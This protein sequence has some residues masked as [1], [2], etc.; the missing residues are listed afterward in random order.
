VALQI[1]VRLLL[2][3]LASMCVWKMACRQ[4]VFA[5]FD[6]AGLPRAVESPRQ[7]CQREGETSWAVESLNRVAIPGLVSLA[8]GPVRRV[9]QRGL[10]CIEEA[11]CLRGLDDFAGA[12][13]GQRDVVL[14]PV[15]ASRC[16]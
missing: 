1:V 13:S 7:R 15:F 16:A 3:H 10:Q 12:Q 5:H 11:L 6:G 14:C 2:P 8:V 4:K 9:D